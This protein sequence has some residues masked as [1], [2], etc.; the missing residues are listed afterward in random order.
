M[1]IQVH[2]WTRYQSKPTQLPSMF[3]DWVAEKWDDF[4]GNRIHITDIRDSNSIATPLT[5]DDINELKKLK[6]RHL[7]SVA[8]MDAESNGVLSYAVECS[9]VSRLS[10][11][12]LGS[13]PENSVELIGKLDGLSVLEI[14]D[15]RLSDKDIASL[16]R[17]PEL[18][19]FS[20]NG[21]NLGQQGVDAIAKSRTLV[22][23]GII[24]GELTSE[25]LCSVLS[26]SSLEHVLLDDCSINNPRSHSSGVT[27][28]LKFLQMSG[29][30]VSSNALHAVPVSAPLEF[31]SM[32]SGTLDAAAAKA[33]AGL[34]HAKKIVIF[35]SQVEDEFFVGLESTNGL[36]LEFHRCDISPSAVERL[37][38]NASVTENKESI[39]V[40]F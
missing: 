1:S 2:H 7:N 35:N 39:R 21:K 27:S 29:V 10:V 20:F 11:G 31:L 24:S 16:S 4:T 34:R 33:L 17:K 15:D 14:R 36:T 12:R 28:G 26:I 38:K 8:L 40:A 32:D 5:G 6:G 22:S 19:M 23:I 30:S 37:Q 13:V 18:Q 25:R 3:P 9:A